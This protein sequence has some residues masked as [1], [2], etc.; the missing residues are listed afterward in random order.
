[1]STIAIAGLLALLAA[2][3]IA[4]LLGFTEVGLRGLDGAEV[5]TLFLT[6]I[7]VALVIERA[8]EVYVAL[9]YGARERELGRESAIAG[10]LLQ[11]AEDAVSTETARQA[12]AAAPDSDRL[13]R[14]RAE[15]DTARKA[16]GQAKVAAVGAA[17]ALRD[18]KARAATGLS[19]GLSVLAALVG[20]RLLGQFL[21]LDEAGR[22]TG[23]FAETCAALARQ[24]GT[25]PAELSAEARAACRSVELQLAAFRLVDVILTAL[26]LA[27]GAEGIHQIAKRVK[28]RPDEI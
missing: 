7:F 19:L 22:L 20:I 18:R 2:G 10:K 3:L 4:N 26:V 8:V 28:P 14:V 17:V 1:M 27:G 23:A 6:L 24:Q 5:G 16:L 15:A 11:V 12:E 21:P 13:A 25:T 9:A